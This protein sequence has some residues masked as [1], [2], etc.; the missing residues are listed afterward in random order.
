MKLALSLDQNSSEGHDKYALLLSSLG[1]SDA[2]LKEINKAISL[3]PFSQETQS[4]VAWIHFVRRDYAGAIEAGEHFASIDST[5]WAALWTLG[6]SLQKSGHYGRAIAVLRRSEKV[7]QSPLVLATLGSAY[8]A[9]GQTAKARAV[10]S[11]LL[12]IQKHEFVCPYETGI[13]YL[14]LGNKDEALKW[15]EKGYETRSICMEV[16]K[17]DPRVDAL[18]NDLRFQRIQ[19]LVMGSLRI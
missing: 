3:D 6:M 5:N 18:R 10:L 14:E 1:E 19:A 8:A 2:A 4:N 11:Q 17:V 13:L 15:I 16:I 7:S 9:A 12:E